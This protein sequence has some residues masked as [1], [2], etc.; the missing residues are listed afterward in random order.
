M[1]GAFGYMLLYIH[2]YIQY[3]VREAAKMVGL[4]KYAPALNDISMEKMQAFNKA[5]SE[6]VLLHHTIPDVAKFRKDC[7]GAKTTLA[8]LV[9]AS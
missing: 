4:W 7:M 8:D 6:V 3:A 5:E 2:M 1:Y 9:G